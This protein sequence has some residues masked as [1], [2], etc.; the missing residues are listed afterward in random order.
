MRLVKTWHVNGMW[1][2]TP[3]FVALLIM[4][5]P[6]LPIRAHTTWMSLSYEKERR[7]Q[8]RNMYFVKAAKET[9]EEDL[10]QRLTNFFHGTNYLHVKRVRRGMKIF[11]FVVLFSLGNIVGLFSRLTKTKSCT[12][13]NASGTILVSLHW[14]FILNLTSDS[15]W[16]QCFKITLLETK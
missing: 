14:R 9:S 10:R 11:F 4:D 12:E 5:D 16:I 15:L 6:T 8:T 3:F 13:L 2:S 7:K 1:L